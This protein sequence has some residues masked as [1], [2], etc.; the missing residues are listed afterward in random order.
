VPLMKL[1]V[2]NIAG[3]FDK[4][5]ILPPDADIVKAVYDFRSQVWRIL[6]SK[7]EE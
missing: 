7:V 6:V 4:S 3:D 2:I 5:M 1:I